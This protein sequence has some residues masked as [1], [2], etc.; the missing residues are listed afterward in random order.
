MFIEREKQEKVIKYE[1]KKC[2]YERKKLSY[3]KKLKKKN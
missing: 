3:R 2:K 1:K